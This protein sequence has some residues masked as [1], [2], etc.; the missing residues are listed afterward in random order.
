MNIGDLKAIIV[1]YFREDISHFTVGGQDLLLVAL[2]SVRKQAELVHDFEYSKVSV[3]LVVDDVIG[4]DLSDAVLSG[5]DDGVDV[6]SVIQVGIVVTGDVV[7]AR[8]STTTSIAKEHLHRRWPR[9]RWDQRYPDDAECKDGRYSRS[10]VL[11]FGSKL[12]RYPFGTTGEQTTLTLEVYKWFADYAEDED[13]DLFTKHGHNYLKWAAI[14]E[15]NHL[16]KRF[17]PRQEGNLAPPTGL[18]D[19][20]LQAL[21]A[22]DEYIVE[23]GRS[24]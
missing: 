21:I 17:V 9:D 8:F 19:Q 12:F 18:A 10:R 15:V 6:K 24:E 13:E 22:W 16:F 11:Q 5:T 20:A 23:G 1:A 7:P 3:D 14:I 4:G 2:N